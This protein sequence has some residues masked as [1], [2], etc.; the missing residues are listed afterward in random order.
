MSLHREPSTSKLGLQCTETDLKHSGTIFRLLLLFAA[1]SEPLSTKMCMLFC[2][3]KRVGV[4]ELVADD[5]SDPD[6]EDV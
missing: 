3:A 2:T 1:S 5:D 4:A 6:I